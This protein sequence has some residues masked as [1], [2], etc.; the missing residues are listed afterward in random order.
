[1]TLKFYQKERILFATEDSIYYTNKKAVQVARKLARH[2]KIVLKGV[3]F[4][5]GRYSYANYL[6]NTIILSNMPSLRVIMHELAHLYLFQRKQVKYR[7]HT[8]KLWK[9]M[10]R[11][12][13]YA[14]KKNYWLS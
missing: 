3:K 2:F 10:A 6:E 1:M 14:K 12:S 11:M 5:K 13:K 8:K 9:I 7:F 4:K